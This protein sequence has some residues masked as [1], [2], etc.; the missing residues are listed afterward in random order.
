MTIVYSAIEGHI[1]P[2]SMRI[3]VVGAYTTGNIA[4]SNESSAAG[5]VSS[6]SSSFA[7]SDFEFVCVVDLA[8]GCIE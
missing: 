3:T 1:G 5:F 2:A 8:S 6:D 4:L 7:A